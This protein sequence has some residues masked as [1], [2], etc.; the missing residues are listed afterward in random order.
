[1]SEAEQIQEDLESESDAR[2]REVGWTPKEQFKG[3][4]DKWVDSS[5]FLERATN[6]MGMLKKNNDALHANV[7]SLNAQIKDMQ[8]TF[9]EFKDFHRQSVETAKNQGYRTAREELLAE[10]R[11]A[12]EAGD[13]D[14]FDRLETKKQNLDKEYNKPVEQPKPVDPVNDQWRNEN[15]WY[16]TDPELTIEANAMGA[17]VNQRYP[18][19]T[20]RAFYDKVTEE[21]R[22]RNPSKFVNPNR[23]AAAVVDEGGASPSPRKRMSQ[24]YENLPPDAKAACDKYVASNLLSKEDYLKEY[25]W[26]E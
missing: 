21:V 8:S 13:T 14:A 18:N 25:D 26:S 6:N 20:G 15:P 9:G 12:V 7:Q 4:P 3:D 1:M 5:Q 19:L 24:T 11:T 22:A 2:A 17:Y 10:Q 23:E 16:E